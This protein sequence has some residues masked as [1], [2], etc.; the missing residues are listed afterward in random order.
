MGF[1]DEDSSE[2]A[3]SIS[4]GSSAGDSSAGRRRRGAGDDVDKML[5]GMRDAS[6]D[7]D[8]IELVT[9]PRRRTVDR[10]G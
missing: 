8:E 6:S 1:E 9:T 5:D 4:R 3:Y 7:E 10:V 2:G